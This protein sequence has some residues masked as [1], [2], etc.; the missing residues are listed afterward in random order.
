MALKKKAAAVAKK[1]TKPP[2]KAEIISQVADKTDLTKKDV[3]AVF[4]ELNAI[5]KKSLR[6]AGEFSMPGLMKIKVV[7]KPATKARLGKNPFTGEEIMI[8]AKPA[9][10]TVKVTALKGLKDMV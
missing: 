5:I 1:A 9:R 10:K 3:T 6:V 2:T 8:K 4:D 7:K